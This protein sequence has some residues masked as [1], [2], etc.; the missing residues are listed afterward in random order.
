M[1]SQVKFTFKT[2]AANGYKVTISDLKITDAWNKADGSYNGTA[3]WTNGVEGEYDFGSIEDVADGTMTAE[4]YYEKSV[5]YKLVIPQD[6]SSNN[7]KVAFTASVDGLG[8]EAATDNKNFEVV[9]NFGGAIPDASTNKWMPQYR[10][11]Y[12]A[13][14]DVTK[15]TEEEDYVIE[16]TPEVEDWADASDTD[17][18]IINPTE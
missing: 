11:N 7:V 13:E 2:K 4:G 6:L 15:L 3:T 17:N 5:D 14:I 12:I 8:Y 16:F 10:Y 9:L 18:G 1:L